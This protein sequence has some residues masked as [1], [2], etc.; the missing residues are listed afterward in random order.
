[1]TER[2]H[3]VGIEFGR[4]KH[5]ITNSEHLVT[6]ELVFYSVFGMMSVVMKMMKFAVCDDE[7]FMVKG[8]SQY[9][10]KYMKE[11]RITSYH[12]D[13]FSSG[14]LLLESE[15]DFDVVFL[16]I[17][18]EQLDGI[19]TAKI[20]RQQKNRSLLIF[21]TV[22]KE[23]VFE[24]FEVE[25]Y[26]YLI[27]P[28]DYA[29]FKRTMNRTIVT[30]E[31]RT[32]QCIVIQRGTACE[33]IPFSGIVYCEVQGRKIYIHEENGKVTD[34]YDKLNSFERRVDRR[35]F[36]C[37]RSYVVNL[38]YVRGIHAGQVTL[39]QGNTIPVS[40]LRERELI[41][42]LLRYMKEKRG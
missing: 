23:C 29:C 18:M 39:L 2:Y 21:I 15:C 40:R 7:P 38:D 8:I 42:T 12:I 34:Y 26:D 35:F 4:R 17:Q 11:Q 3:N 19:K 10:S 30:L 28:I 33:V 6:E 22:L 24:A 25:A 13:N 36:K 5:P 20:L 32:S 14:R 31:Q 16:D 37:H 9:I 1:M 27:K 41:E